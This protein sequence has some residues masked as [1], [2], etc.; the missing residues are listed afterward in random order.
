VDAGDFHFL[1][2]VGP[3]P[4]ALPSLTLRI[5]IRSLICLVRVIFRHPQLRGRV[6]LR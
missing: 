6:R 5:L 2:C 4:H 1:I 3:H